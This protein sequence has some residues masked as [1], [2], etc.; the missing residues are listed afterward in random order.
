M[1]FPVADGDLQKLKRDALS[2]AVETGQ[3]KW[4]E[5]V[6]YGSLITFIPK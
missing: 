3:R 5:T 2:G 1:A 4:D 6:A